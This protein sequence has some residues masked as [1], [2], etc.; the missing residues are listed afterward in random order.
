MILRQTVTELCTAMPATPVLRT[1]MQYSI[2]ICS[3]PETVSDVISGIYI[4]HVNGTDFVSNKHVEFR[5]HRLNHSR[6]IP[7][8]PV[9]GGIFDCF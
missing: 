4:R 1:F 5:E 3:R 2:A 8:E 9:G 7:L 6:E